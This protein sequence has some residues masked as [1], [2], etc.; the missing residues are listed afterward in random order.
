MY[1]SLKSLNEIKI[2]LQSKTFLNYQTQINLTLSLGQGQIELFKSDS[3]YNVMVC[4]QTLLKPTVLHLKSEWR[5]TK[6]VS[7]N[8]GGTVFKR[9]IKT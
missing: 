5:D 6:Y 9:K 2:H 4:N 1:M 7:L 8:L 3:Q